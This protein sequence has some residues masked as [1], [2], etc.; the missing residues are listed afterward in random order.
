[1]DTYFG[2]PYDQLYDGPFRTPFHLW[3]ICFLLLG[4]IVGSFL[5]VVIYRLPLDLSTVTP[6]SHC[7]KCNTRIKL[8]H[9]L[10]VL[11]WLLLRGRCA[12]CAA[13]IPPR[14]VLVEAF[15]GL[16]F[17]AT[18]LKF[19]RA[20]PLMALAL[21]L[22]FAG[23][24]AAT[25]IDLEH[26]IIPDQITIGGIFAGF[27]FC[28]AVPPLVGQTTAVNGMKFSALGAA[29]GGGMV[30][31]VLR[32]GKMLFGKQRVK[33][34]DGSRITFTEEAI[35]LPD[36]AVYYDEVFYRTSDTV[37]LEAKRLE[38]SDRCYWNQPVRLA[39]KQS[40]PLL[41]I[42]EEKLDASQEPWMCAD[43][44]K[45]TLPREAMGFGDVKF[46]GGIGAFLGWHATL[47]SLM[48]SAV[49]GSLV[50]VGLIAAGK[51]DWSTRLPY[52]PF[53]AAAATLWV[54]G[55]KEWFFRLFAR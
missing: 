37:I 28:A 17:V 20:E 22:L 47:F 41:Q 14:Y 50:G 16:T 32:G 18:W 48:A 7:P 35:H 12:Y 4:L 9:N 6:P 43:T 53:I 27:L 2:I 36:G 1:M 34:P 5:N 23:F 42:G 38:L 10:P 13:A 15:S 46:M 29:V 25:A 33:I 45:V 19:G 39:C 51:R 8:R 21:C 30:Y 24:I 26:Y 44:E 40:P 11:S 55:G 52:G 49:L 54:W 31:A 3:T